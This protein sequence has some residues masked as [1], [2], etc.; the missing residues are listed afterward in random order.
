MS[1]VNLLANCMHLLALPFTFLEIAVFIIAVI[2]FILAVRFF[3]ASQKNLENLLPNP[4]KKRKSSIGISIDRDGFIVPTEK[5]IR[6]AHAEK[7]QYQDEETRHEIKELRDMLQLQQ[8]ELTRALR[9]IESINTQKDEPRYKEKK[10][11]DE[12]DEYEDYK[13]TYKEDYKDDFQYRSEKS[14]LTEELRQQLER[15]EAEVRELRQQV[16]RKPSP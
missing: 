10:Y 8:L 1:A 6:K 7:E 5:Q 3:I 9:Q 14:A 16:E 12:E 15:K 4:K 13:D 2:A 11:Y